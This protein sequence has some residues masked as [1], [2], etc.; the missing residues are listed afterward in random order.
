MTVV[1]SGDQLRQQRAGERFGRSD[2]HQPAAQL[3]E[4]GQ[5]VERLVQA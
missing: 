3:L 1:V 2:T 5:V 4:I